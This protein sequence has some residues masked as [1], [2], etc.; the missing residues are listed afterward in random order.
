MR[1]KRKHIP[2]V[3]AADNSY[4][5]TWPYFDSMQ[6][7]DTSL[8]PRGTSGNL[9]PYTFTDSSTVDEPTDQTVDEPLTQTPNEAENGTTSHVLYENT[10]TNPVT[11]KE[12]YKKRIYVRDEIDK[13]ILS[14]STKYLQRLMMTKTRT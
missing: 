6:F 3:S 8:M 4:K 12:R 1:E 2:S 14:I 9:P 5:L 13:K 10:P 7:L 11:S